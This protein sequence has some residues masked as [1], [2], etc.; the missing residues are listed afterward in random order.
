M[1][2]WQKIGAY[3][4]Y[5]VGSP[6][7]FSLQFRIFHSISIIAFLA[8]AYNV[9]FNYFIGLPWIALVSFVVLTIL[10][11]IYY[12]SR[13]KNKT[14]LS[15]VFFCVLANLLFIAN[16][17]INWGISGPTDILMAGTLLLMI[18]TA[19]PKQYKI[20]IPINIAVILSLHGIEYRYPLLV[21]N[22]YVTVADR[23]LDVSSA[24][25]VVVVLM[26]YTVT[27]IRKNYEL[28]RKSSEDRAQ[29][30]EIKNQYILVQNLELERLNAEKNKLMSIIAHDLRS[31]LGNIQNYLELLDEYSLDAEERKIIEKD[32]LKLTQDTTSMLSKVL[33]WSKAQMDGVTVKLNSVNLF[34][35]LANTL[36]LEKAIAGKKGIALSYGVEQTIK[37]MADVDMLQLIVRNLINN[38]IKFT[39][40]GGEIEISASSIHNNCLLMVKDTGT[41]I[42]YEQQ[43]DLFS[44]KA[45]STFGTENEKGI[46]LGLKL[47][48]EFTELQAGE[49]WMESIPGKGTAFYVSLP[50]ALPVT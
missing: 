32:L 8:L 14:E 48:K 6:H 4:N 26:Y 50:L 7:S 34:E 39:P 9:P 35:A 47:C 24:Y 42:P 36:E 3:W 31:P 28:E 27:Y 5:L 29:S 46:G 11:Y 40:A 38:A 2:I 25:L 13:F 16:Y 12:L 22:T 10:C 15:I 18:S 44:L 33:S 49:I 21:P 1:S 41:G 20:W 45:T 43:R 30:I 17:F 23:F 37:I 19:P